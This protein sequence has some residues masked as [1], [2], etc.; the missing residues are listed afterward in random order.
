[1]ISIEQQNQLV[2]VA[3]LGQFNL[4]DFKELEDAVLYKIKFDGKVNLLFDLRD[5]ASATIDTA[6]EDIKFTRQHRL[7]LNK[8][9]VVTASRWVA[10]SAWLT[11]LFGGGDIKVFDDY[12][13]AREWVAAV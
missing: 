10:W 3:V 7:E 12:T 13:L 9:A 1:M 2:N 8:I 11:G 6:W 5:L 4:A